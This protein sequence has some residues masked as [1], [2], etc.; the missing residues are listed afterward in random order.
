M[1]N[2]TGIFKFEKK[3]PNRFSYFKLTIRLV[4]LGKF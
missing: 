2:Q 4:L 3:K 1:T